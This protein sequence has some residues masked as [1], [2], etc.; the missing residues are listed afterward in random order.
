MAGCAPNVFTVLSV[1]DSLVEQ[2]SLSVNATLPVIPISIENGTST[3]LYNYFSLNPA[4]IFV[5]PGK[6]MDDFGVSTAC[7]KGVACL[8]LKLSR[9]LAHC[10]TCCNAR[11]FAVL[12]LC[13]PSRCDEVLVNKFFFTLK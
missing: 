6:K 11:H 1:A 2:P 8:L 7:C 9:Q 3:T 10:L 13:Y 5:V 12:S 4:I